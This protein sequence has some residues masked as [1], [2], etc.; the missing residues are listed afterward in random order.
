MQ[1]ELLVKSKR[2]RRGKGVWLGLTFGKSLCYDSFLSRENTFDLVLIM[3]CVMGNSL[4]L[5][6]LENC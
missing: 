5:K 4:F 3:P 2:V 6:R 1:R